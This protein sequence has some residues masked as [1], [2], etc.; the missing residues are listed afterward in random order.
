MPRPGTSPIVLPGEPEPVGEVPIIDVTPVPMG[1]APLSL[2]GR[3]PAVLLYLETGRGTGEFE[4]VG[5][6]DWTNITRSQDGGDTTAAI[7]RGLDAGKLT[8]GGSIGDE[9]FS[10]VLERLHPDYRVRIASRV[11]FAAEVHFQGYPMAPSF[12]WDA[13]KQTVSCLCL[14]EGQEILRTDRD[15]QVIGRFM[16]YDPSVPWDPEQP[17]AV[18]VQA[19]AP[20]FNAGNRPN[21]S[22]TAYP[23][24]IGETVHRVHLFTEDNAPDA[25]SWS[26]AEALRYLAFV[27]VLRPALGVSAADFMADT[28]GLVEVGPA[29]GATDPFIR[30]MCDTVEDLAAGSM[31]A[32]EA[33]GLV[34]DT[35]GLHYEIAIRNVGQ[36]RDV[37]VRHYLR[38]YAVLEKAEQAGD[39]PERLM[40]APVV[41]DIPREAPFTDMAGRT[42]GQIALANQAPMASVTIDRRAVNR[43]LVIGSPQEYEC[44][45]LMRPGWLPHGSLD[46]LVVYNEDGTVDTEA[47]ETLRAEAMDYWLDE[48][49]PEFTGDES[50]MPRSVY[51]GSHPLHPAVNE[52][53]R[54]WLF[55]DDHR[56]LA[57]DGVSSPYERD[58]WPWQLYDPIDPDDPERTALV[59]TRSDIGGGIADSRLWVPRRRPLRETIGRRL[60]AGDRA[61]IVEFNFQA[62]AITVDEETGAIDAT[63]LMADANWVE[64]STQPRIDEYRAAIYLREHNLLTAPP[65]LAEPANVYGMSML[66]AYI[67]GHFAVRVTC[68]LRGDNRMIRRPSP[69]GASMERRRFQTIDTGLERFAKRD[70]RGGN[71]ILND[72]PTDGDPEYESRDDTEKLTNFAD[73]TGERTVGDAVS[74]SVDV[75]WLDR[76][77]RLGDSFAGVSGLGIEFTRYPEIVRIEYV[78]DARASYRTKLHVTDLRDA[79]EVGAE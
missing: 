23:F 41:R 21:R 73:R 78:K 4:P 34:V 30:R 15:A 25:E 72:E 35:A 26:Y 58:G 3:H 40:I 51:H 69:T 8:V 56:L 70:R 42:A 53:G 61:P 14:S 17:D 50:R 6:L 33:I 12:H 59:L 77:Y 71:S 38:I 54:L 29:P 39:V 43:P 63:A 2:R 9:H 57:E 74:G 10:Q 31:N 18:E 64:D 46:N 37:V 19:L 47:T 62:P 52:V 7:S 5:G 48:F 65:F 36:D 32:E 1:N 28:A 24:T 49:D 68:V 27:H 22:A 16:R 20:V 45:L 66:E 76:T 79:P 75:F 11:G 60:A 13:R 55:P 67:H 44:T